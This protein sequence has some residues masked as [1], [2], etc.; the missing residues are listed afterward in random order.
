MLFKLIKLKIIHWSYGGSVEKIITFNKV[1]EKWK[2]TD[3]DITL[4]LIEIS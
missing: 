2:S 1:G 4:K 3:G